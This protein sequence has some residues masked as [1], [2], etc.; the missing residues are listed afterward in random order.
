ME[1]KTRIATKKQLIAGMGLDSFKPAMR[2][3]FSHYD[4]YDHHGETRYRPIYKEVEAGHLFA[5]AHGFT[6]HIHESGRVTLD[7]GF[8]YWGTLFDSKVKGK[9]LT[10]RKQKAVALLHEAIAN[11]GLK[12]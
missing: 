12:D 4:T 10:Q 7:S 8:D 5:H 3:V 1:T 9:T 2:T 6:A 11:S